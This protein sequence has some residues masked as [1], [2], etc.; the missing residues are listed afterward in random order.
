VLDQVIS[1]DSDAGGVE[2]ALSRQISLVVSENV[3]N[4]MGRVVEGF[5]QYP[6][7]V[8]WLKGK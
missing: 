1:R 4:T 8:V 6:K 5:E 2:V 7:L 3:A